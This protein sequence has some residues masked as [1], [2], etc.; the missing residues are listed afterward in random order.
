MKYKVATKQPKLSFKT[1]VGLAL[2]A[3]LALFLVACENVDLTDVIQ[4]PVE[5]IESPTE[6][7]SDQ[8]PTDEKP[9][10][11]KPSDEKPSDEKPSDEKP[12]DEK[13]EEQPTSPKLLMP[14]F[15]IVD[16]QI[17]PKAVQNLFKK[18]EVDVQVKEGKGS[19]HFVDRDKFMNL[20]TFET[21]AGFSEEDDA[22]TV[23]EAFDLKQLQS[24]KPIDQQTLNRLPEIVQEALQESDLFPTT[25]LLPKQSDLVSFN[26][27]TETSKFEMF[28]KD[29]EK[30]LDIDIDSHVIGDLSLKIKD[31]LVPVVGPGAKVKAVFNRDNRITQLYYAIYPMQESSS[32]AVISSEEA[33][34]ACMDVYGRVSAKLQTQLMYYVPEQVQAGAKI[35]PSYECQTPEN[36]SDTLLRSVYIDGTTGKPLITSF[37]KIPSDDRNEKPN[38]LLQRGGRIDVGT[39]WIGTSQG[40]AGSQDNAG[41]FVSKM[42][43]EGYHVSFNFGDNNAWERDFK[44]PSQVATG[45]DTSFVDNVDMLFYTGH[46]NA[47]NFT[48]PGTNDDG[49][50]E[51]TENPRWGNN[52]LEWLI[53]A[54]CGPLQNSNGAEQSW[55]TRWGPAFDGLHMMLAYANVSNDN[56]VEGDKMAS[57]LVGNELDL[58]FITVGNP[59][60]K[61]RTAWIETATEVQSSRVTWAVMGPFGPGGQ[62]SYNDYFHG[63][64]GVSS[65]IDNP[66]GFWKIS[67]PS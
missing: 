31:G 41:G 45:Q 28:S 32:V 54:A 51:F 52:D 57:K 3:V 36:E 1:K 23:N 5:P 16:G 58:W 62:T 46:A 8:K 39:E 55:A 14:V 48:F 13:P 9:S 38:L 26:L 17:D 43:S 22:K 11:E 66:T 21:Q 15:E 50:L 19:V 56:T 64:G 6:Q 2:L 18:L 29:D 47:N 49:R 4:Q 63:K 40:L 61:V 24:L 67:G 27:R 7:P 44:D 30:L 59:P 35:T 37:G 65:D 20:P 60:A 12:S 33:E 10:D 25:S 42:G 53:I 34:K